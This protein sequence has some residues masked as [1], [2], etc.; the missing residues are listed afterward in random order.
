MKPLH[1]PAYLYGIDNH[2]PIETGRQ[3]MG[4]HPLN[5]AVCGNQLEEFYPKRY[6]LQ[7]YFHA[8]APAPG[9]RFEYVQGL[10]ARCLAYT[11]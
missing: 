9:R 2:L 7:A 6:L 4:Y 11:S 8:P 1:L 3:V 10:V 5:A